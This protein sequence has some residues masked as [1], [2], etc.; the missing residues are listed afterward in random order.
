[1][2]PEILAVAAAAGIKFVAPLI[3]I[4]G[5]IASLETVQSKL[6]NR[7]DPAQKALA[8]VLEELAKNCEAVSS[9]VGK[10]TGLW[11]DPSGPARDLRREWQVLT[12]LKRAPLEARLEETR[13]RCSKI[14]NIYVKYLSGWFSQVLSGAE[15]ET[16]RSLFREMSEIDSQMVD[17]IALLVDWLG[18]EVERTLALV[19]Q[20]DYVGANLR[21]EATRDLVLPLLVQ[22]SDTIARL[23]RLEGE[24]ITQSRA[25]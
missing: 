25:T 23:R 20:E 8:T 24:F 16:L 3:G 15:S 9:E 10:Y 14:W 7:P 4:L 11:F 17:V 6:L 5:K 19:N 21:V 1:M 12:M 2:D 13:S 22:L 18:G